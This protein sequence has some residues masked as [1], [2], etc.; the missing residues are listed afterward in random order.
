MINNFDLIVI[1]G[2]TAGSNIMHSAANKGLKVAVIENEHLGGSC[3]NVGCIPSKAL[4]H[5]ARVMQQVREA[6]SFGINT[7]EPSADWQAIVRRKDKIVGNMRQG[8]YKG[9]EEN[10]NITLF[11]GEAT[12]AGPGKVKVND[13]TLS[14]ARVVIAAGARPATPPIPGIDEVEYLNSTSVMELKKLPESLLII[15]GGIIALE[16]SQLFARLGVKVT[17]LQR[18]ML[19]APILEEDISTEIRKLLEAEG[20]EVITGAEVSGLGRSGN[21]IYALEKS[22]GKEVRYS[23]EKILIATGRTP[24]SDRLALNSAG[25]K[26]DDKG[27][28]AVD[29][30]FKTSGHNI[31]AIGDI[32]GG[33]MFTHKAWH[34]GFLLAKHLLDGENIKTEGRLIPYAIFTDPEIAAVGMGEKEAAAA[35]L[36][37]EVKHYPFAN[38]G[39]NMVDGKLKGFVKL[40]AEKKSDRLLGAHLIGSEAAELLHELIAAIRFEAKL[41][42]LQDM[43]HI[44]PTLAEAINSTAFK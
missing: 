36:D 41:W 26:V 40:V 29:P 7:S 6:A 22:S 14:A 18:N 3:V 43:M 16:F 35:G 5:S 37:I 9:V 38:H 27:Y 23:A 28:I 13:E 1:G 30:N 17:I 2:G 24:N 21:K 33:P 10:K 34:D 19:L 11:E 31:W 15:G 25:V 12:F 44:H 42:D 20:V 39:R 8:G 32:I 4:I